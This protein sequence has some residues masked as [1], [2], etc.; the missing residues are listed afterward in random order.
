MKCWGLIRRLAMLK[1]P[2]QSL[3]VIIL[4]YKGIPFETI[5]NKDTLIFIPAA[6]EK[7]EKHFKLPPGAGRLDKEDVKDDNFP[8]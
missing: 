1:T 7:T 8:Y 4:R 6:E 5:Y 2:D 3:Q